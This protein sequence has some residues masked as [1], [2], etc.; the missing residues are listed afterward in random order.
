VI[1]QGG[2]Q[3]TANTVSDIYQQ[4]QLTALREAMFVVF[5]VSILSIVFSKNLP[6]KISTSS[7]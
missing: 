6:A 3:A 5:A 2:S 1:S 4:S 7:A